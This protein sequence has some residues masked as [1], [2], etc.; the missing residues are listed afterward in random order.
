MLQ[1]ADSSFR[2]EPGTWLLLEARSLTWDT[3]T[4]G[5][6][7]TYY[8]AINRCLFQYGIFM[9]QGNDEHKSLS[10]EYPLNQTRIDCLIDYSSLLF[11]DYS[12]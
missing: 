11:I 8:V 1:V 12:S 10:T 9:P 7:T 5:K 4:V 2:R 3:W 6:R